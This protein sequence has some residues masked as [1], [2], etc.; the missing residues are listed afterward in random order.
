[1]EP[2]TS[3]DVPR[4]NFGRRVAVPMFP[5]IPGNV[6]GHYPELRDPAQWRFPHAARTRSI[7]AAGSV[8]ITIPM[9]EMDAPEWQRNDT[10]S[11]YSQ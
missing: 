1:M 9:A 7:I 8:R 10:R 3:T 4:R 5:L 2:S 6:R 11:A